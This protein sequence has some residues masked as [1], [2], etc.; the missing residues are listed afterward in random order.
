VSEP[1]SFFVYVDWT[2]E[3]LPRP[4]YVGKGTAIRV[5]HIRRN[6]KH[7]FVS[8]KH[9]RRRTVMWYGDYDSCAKTIEIQLIAELHT[10]VSDP[11]ASSI[12]CNFTQGGDGNLG[13]TPSEATR[14][15]IS[16]TKTGKPQTPE[17][18]EQSKQT[19]LKIAR[20]PDVQRKKGLA[21]RGKP[22]SPAHREK[23]RQ[24]HMGLKPS[25]ETRHKM[26]LSHQRRITAKNAT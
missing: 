19:L 23:I 8:A 4:F 21:L 1:T 15:K 7:T 11:F 2:S 14:K 26:S 5:R 25:D 12:A 13:C 10:Y 3:P 20:D 6:K 17:V 9:G 24:S 16:H 22:K 18:R